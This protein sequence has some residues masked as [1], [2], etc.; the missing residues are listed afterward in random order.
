[1][2]GVLPPGREAVEK[3]GEILLDFLPFYLHPKKLKSIKEGTYKPDVGD[4]LDL[5]DIIPGAKPVTIAAKPA[6]KAILIAPAVAERFLR[7]Y[8][9]IL[10]KNLEKL[11]KLKPD[12][13]DPEKMAS[14][15]SFVETRFPRLFSKVSRVDVLPLEEMVRRLIRESVVGPRQEDLAKQ[16]GGMYNPNTNVISISP[17]II[18]NLTPGPGEVVPFI[19]NFET[20]AAN[21]IAHELA[22]A[23]QANRSKLF[24]QLVGPERAMQTPEA[25]SNYL[26]SPIEVGA[27]RQGLLRTLEYPYMMQQRDYLKTGKLNPFSINPTYYNLKATNVKRYVPM[28]SPLEEVTYRLG[29]V[30]L[31]SELLARLINQ[32]LAEKYPDVATR[33]RGMPLFTEGVIPSKVWGD[34]VR[35]YFGGNTM[36]KQPAELADI[37]AP[38]VA[39][40]FLYNRRIPSIQFGKLI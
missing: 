33:V 27:R 25:V 6:A 40:G 12:F 31:R 21:T 8:E 26:L 23:A 19:N 28:T 5:T 29:N 20:L 10:Q 1:M 14:L 30:H 18:E 32:R 16:I 13:Y 35:H 38:Y 7:R 2:P 11:T 39:E 4:V 34:N 24:Y 15:L 36:K 22:H 9:P 3:L 37:L 17:Q